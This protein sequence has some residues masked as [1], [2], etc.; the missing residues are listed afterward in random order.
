MPH[1]SRR[2]RGSYRI[3]ILS[4]VVLVSFA[5]SGCGDFTVYGLEVTNESD[6]TVIVAPMRQIGPANPSNGRAYLFEPGARGWVQ[7]VV[8][9]P[10]SPTKN[11]ASVFV[12]DRNCSTIWEQ[13]VDP[14]DYRLVI[15]QSD[16]TL[17]D[18]DGPPPSD[19]SVFLPTEVCGFASD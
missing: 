17:T 5:L 9:G 2:P 12:L 11:R 8:V 7:D 10:G 16:I 1:L 19:R 15:G 13:D 3:S 14:G 18:H 4:L 6:T